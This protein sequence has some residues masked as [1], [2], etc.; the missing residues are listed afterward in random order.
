MSAGKHRRM[1]DESKLLFQWSVRESS[2]GR[3]LVFGLATVLGLGGFFFVFR[4]V[5]PESRREPLMTRRVTV[6]SSEDPTARPIIQ[7]AI[8]QSFALLPKP[9]DPTEAL[10]DFRP[11]FAGYRMRLKSL[12]PATTEAFN[13]QMLSPTRPVLSPLAAPRRAAP[14]APPKPRQLA[15]RLSGAASDRLVK[16]WS[17]GDL[18]LADT[19]RTRFRIGIDRRGRVAFMLPLEPLDEN[20]TAAALEKAVAALSFAPAE[21]PE[22]LWTDASFEWEELVEP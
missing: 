6:L 9:E 1:E 11:S 8:D 18:Q 5:Y 22:I 7:R 16:P 12:T 2:W 17:R 21:S 15:L 10:P 4:V 19:A 14:P 3:L 20:K 13:V